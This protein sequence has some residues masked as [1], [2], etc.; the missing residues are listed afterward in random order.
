M[1]LVIIESPYAGDVEKNIH[2]ARRAMLDSLSRDEAPIA[3]HL[4]YPQVLDDLIP[5]ER[6]L[7]IEA[8]LAWRRV[9]ELSAFYVD[10]AWSRGMVAAKAL[11]DREGRP[12]SIRALDHDICEGCGG[13][14]IIVAGRGWASAVCPPMNGCGGS[15]VRPRSKA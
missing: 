4:L 7:G 8:G 11:L 15:G 10:L 13:T 3:S 2:Y 9:A 1:R 12:Y 14:G 6:Q 5:G